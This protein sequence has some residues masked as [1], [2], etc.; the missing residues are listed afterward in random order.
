MADIRPDDDPGNRGTLTIHD[1]VVKQLATRAVLET[2][3]VE[4]QSAGI[5][6]LTGRALPR[7]HVQISGDR[8]RAGVDIAVAWA[9]PLATV[10]ADVQ[11]NVTHALYNW[12]GLYVDAVD[13]SVPEVVN[14]DPAVEPRVR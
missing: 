1:K 12:A 3:G 11:A 5:D 7:V 4:R 2:A 14:T 13:V 6:K 9:V 8:V 10:A